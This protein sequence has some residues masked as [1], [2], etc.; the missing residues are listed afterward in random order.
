MRLIV[1]RGGSCSSK[2]RALVSLK[3]KLWDRQNGIVNVDTDI[4][5]AVLF[6]QSPDFTDGVQD[7]EG[8]EQ[9]AGMH[10]SKRIIALMKRE[11]FV[12]VTSLATL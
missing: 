5:Y 10:F 11:Q 3:G 2:A 7:E 1:T 9:G 8:K 12:K 4:R 6:G